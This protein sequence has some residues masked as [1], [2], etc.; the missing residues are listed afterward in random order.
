MSVRKGAEIRLNFLVFHSWARPLILFVFPH[1]KCNALFRR[2]TRWKR[3]PC[4]WKVWC[5]QWKEFPEFLQPLPK[6]VSGL[7]G[8]EGVIIKSSTHCSRGK[9]ATE[10]FEEQAGDQISSLFEL[11]IS[12]F[13]PSEPETVSSGHKTLCPQDTHTQRKAVKQ[14]VTHPDVYSNTWKWLWLQIKRL[15]KTTAVHSVSR[16][17]AATSKSGQ[18]DGA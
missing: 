12:F 11:G 5:G 6:N 2:R 7:R 1:W 16:A 10:S 13:S 8:T 14:V 4:D 18:R 15:G 17:T 3:I 9:W